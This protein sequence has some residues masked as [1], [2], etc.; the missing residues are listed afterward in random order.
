[1]IYII[2]SSEEG[3][4]NASLKRILTCLLVAVM[5]FSITV[6]AIAQTQADVKINTVSTI[7]LPDSVNLKVYFNLFD[8]ST[9]RA[10]T[11]ITPETAQITLLNTGLSSSAEIKQPDI[12][13]YITMEICGGRLSMKKFKLW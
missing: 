11:N 3:R 8:K 10:I 1:M 5:F 9:N 13:I 2:Q 6:V 4:L 7:E 12:P